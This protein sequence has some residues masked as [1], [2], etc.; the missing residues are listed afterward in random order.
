M[1]L[2]RFIAPLPFWREYANFST[3]RP[4]KDEAGKRWRPYAEFVNGFPRIL[5]LSANPFIAC[6]L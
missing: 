5:L 1:A 4:E 6:L 3:R 2:G